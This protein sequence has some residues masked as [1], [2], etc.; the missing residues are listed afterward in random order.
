MLSYFG[1][2][3]EALMIFNAAAFGVGMIAVWVV[4]AV[5]NRRHRRDRRYFYRRRDA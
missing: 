5:E 3:E 2:S 4:S 1:L